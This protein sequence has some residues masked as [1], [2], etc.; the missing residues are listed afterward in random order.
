M[1]TKSTARYLSQY[2]PLLGSQTRQHVNW[3]FSGAQKQFWPNAL[4]LP[5]TINAGNGG[6]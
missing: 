6:N 5:L 1:Q 3:G 2:N 4:S